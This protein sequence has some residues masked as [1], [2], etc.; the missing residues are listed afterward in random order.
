MRLFK[1]ESAFVLDI[2]IGLVR[3]K[4]TVPEPDFDLLMPVVQGR[5]VFRRRCQ[6]CCA[7]DFEHCCILPSARCCASGS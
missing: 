3:G 2:R 5:K 6:D 7:A 4:D 1:L